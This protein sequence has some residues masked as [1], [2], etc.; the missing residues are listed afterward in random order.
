MS[1]KGKFLSWKMV[2]GDVI[3]ETGGTQERRAVSVEVGM[4]VTINPI[5]LSIERV[6]KNVQL[7]I[8]VQ[9]RSSRDKSSQVSKYRFGS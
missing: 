9:I 7:A 8:E 6:C 2:K 1:R 5:R 4:K 3:N